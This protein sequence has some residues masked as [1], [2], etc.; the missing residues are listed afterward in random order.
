MSSGESEHGDSPT[1]PVPASPAISGPVLPRETG[2]RLE[3]IAGN[4]AGTIIH[5]EDDLVVGR[6]AAGAGQLAED[7]EISRQHA[8]ITREA[9]GEFA[10]EDLGSSNGTF[11]NGLKLAT[12]HL[13]SEGDSIEVGATTLVVQSIVSTTSAAPEDTQPTGLGY[14]PTIFARAPLSENAVPSAEPDTL[15]ARGQPAPLTLKLEVDFEKREASITLGESGEPIRL[16]L[17]NGR[18]QTPHPGS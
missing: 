14:A 18:W 1:P 8:H 6:Y 17:E 4:A 10:I 12:P 9:S 2:L 15:R 3:V 5:V 13:L 11:V 16:V 7:S